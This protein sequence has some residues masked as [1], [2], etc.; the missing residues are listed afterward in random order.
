[1]R[2]GE[3]SDF[4]NTGDPRSAEI[5]IVYVEAKDT[6]QEIL[7]AINLFNMQ[8]RKQ[9]VLVLSEPRQVFR[10]SVDFDGLKRARR[11]LRADVL[12]IAQSGSPAADFA[13]SRHFP[14]YSSL[15]S[16]KHA[17]LDESSDTLHTQSGPSKK[18][19]LLAFGSRKVS[20]PARAQPAAMTRGEQKADRGTPG[21]PGARSLPPGMPGAPESGQAP[22]A[23]PFPVVPP[24]PQ[25]QGSP[26]SPLPPAEPTPRP[27][28]QPAAPGAGV[29]PTPPLPERADVS[30][31]APLQRGPRGARAPQATDKAAASGP[32]PTH[33]GTPP[34]EQGFPSSPPPTP[35]LPEQALPASPPPTPVD[36]RRPQGKVISLANSRKEPPSTQDDTS[37]AQPDNATPDKSGDAPSGTGTGTVPS[38]Q[39][40]GQPGM[41]LADIPTQPA[42]SDKHAGA[43]RRGL[44]GVRSGTSTASTP[45]DQ[46]QMGELPPTPVKKRRKGGSEAP[47]AILF[48]GG[49]GAPA[50]PNKNPAAQPGKAAPGPGKSPAEQ[51]RQAPGTQQ[52]NAAIEGRFIGSSP[53]K[54]GGSPGRTNARPGQPQP[55]PTASGKA[56]AAP[57]QAQNAPIGPGNAPGQRQNAS[58]GPGRA[59]V[60]AQNAPAGPGTMPGQPQ[61]VPA[62]PGNGPNQ[63]QRARSGPGKIA[64][65]GALGAAALAADAAHNGP[66]N[67]ARPGNPNQPPRNM[68]NA[69][70]GPNQPPAGPAGTAKLAAV[71]GNPNG[72]VGQPIKTTRQVALTPLPSPVA[73]RRRRLMWRRSLLVLGLLLLLGGLVAALLPHSPLNGIITGRV[74][75]T[76][77]I[78]PFHKLEMN[79]FFMTARPGATTSVANRQVQARTLS[80]TSPTQTATANATGSIQA[81]AASG[82]LTFLNNNNSGVT[83]GSTTLTSKNG[84]RISFNGPIFVPAI[85]SASTA[86]YAVNGG[87]AGNIPAFDFS[88]SCCA[89][90]ITVNNKSAFTGGQDAV[91]NSVI[92]QS[93]IDGAVN[94]LAGAQTTATKAD[95]QK[96]V[97]Q[98][99][100][101]VDNTVS[102]TPTHTADH[103]P[104]DQAKQVTVSVSVQCTQEVY[105]FGA[106][107]Q[108]A[109]GLLQGQAENDRDLT[110]FTQ[111]ALDGQVV[112]NLVSA[113]VVKADGQ[114]ALTIQAR[115][116]WVYQFT[117]QMLQNIKHQLLKLSQHDAQAILQNTM[118]VQ[119]SPDAVKIDISSGT[120]MPANPDDITLTVQ[121]LPGASG[122]PVTSTPP[123]GGSNGTATP[124]VGPGPGT[125]G[126]SNAPGPGIFGNPG[127]PNNSG[128][129]GSNAP[130]P[131]TP[132]NPGST[133]N[134]GGSSAPGP[135]T[136]GSP[137]NPGSSNG[138]LA[139]PPARHS[140]P[141][142]VSGLGGS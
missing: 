7:T 117:D 84:V 115:G 65:A 75:A 93:D 116:L 83:L 81:T 108:M 62:G 74:T 105:D 19:G 95:L 135:G 46:A 37:I 33:Q 94:P 138:P 64:A 104:G 87:A 30:G 28:N 68:P 17:L 34:T 130:G 8:G 126:G 131:G 100:R 90:G 78:T 112:T 45:G 27:Q 4:L 99:E 134:P 125:P 139:S 70:G 72:P 41:H 118:G 98:N 12:V 6:R 11:D 1:M 140:T 15:E 120:T 137:N 42:P 26:L 21:G 2:Q 63:S 136:P 16:L 106:A 36:P 114:V 85:G 29:P 111:Y 66:G 82:T 31:P 89:P 86:G 110:P 25:Q 77:T 60:Q 129:S 22:E 122:P 39:P 102:C 35:R 71:G 44:W 69:A 119:H 49:T 103:K 121:K 73:A 76:V 14:V 55:A 124:G 59:P 109:T 3:G 24:T 101:V 23:R 43:P 40:P 91:P 123:P 48:P 13:R 107:V 132:G 38:A 92:Q 79:N 58:A 128:G 133:G 50:G 20:G 53:D 113:S 5:G 97:R 96:Q 80:S 54:S 88:G 18:P 56:P 57:G 67:P 141:T 10:E 61:N 47:G 52:T 127:S 51:T 32:V 9:I 142:P